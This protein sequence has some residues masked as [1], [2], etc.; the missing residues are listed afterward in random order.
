MS[1]LEKNRQDL[2]AV[3]LVVIERFAD[4]SVN[5]ERKVSN[6]ALLKGISLSLSFSDG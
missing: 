6:S 1:S 3:E 4:Q 2:R 5:R